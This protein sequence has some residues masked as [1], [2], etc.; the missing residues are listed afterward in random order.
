MKRVFITDGEW[1]REYVDVD[2]SHIEERFM[3]DYYIHDA[4]EVIDERPASCKIVC[5]YGTYDGRPCL[6]DPLNQIDIY[7]AGMWHCV[8]RTYDNGKRTVQVLPLQA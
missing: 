5:A 3:R 7:N 2:F 4:K 6:K 8:L 1:K